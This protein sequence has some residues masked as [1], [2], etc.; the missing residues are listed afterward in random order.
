MYREKHSISAVW[1]YLQL[2]ASPP[3]L[4]NVPSVEGGNYSTARAENLTAVL[5]VTG[6]CDSGTESCPMAPEHS[7]INHTHYHSHVY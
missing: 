6:H 7:S 3:G 4:Q 2:Q 5:I 1:N